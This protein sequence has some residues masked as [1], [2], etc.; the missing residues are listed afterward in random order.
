M[1]GLLKL[2]WV[3]TK[4]YLRE[5]GVYFGLALP[6][7]L[8]LVF[9][10]L[11]GNTP[12]SFTGGHGPMDVYTPAYIAMMI[13]SYSFFSLPI[14]IINYRE[15][16]ILFRLKA[17]PLRPQVILASHIGANFLMTTACS[18]IIVLLVRVFYDVHI[19]LSIFN[20]FVAYILGVISIFS[21]GFLLASLI[22]SV[23]I[24]SILN[25]ILF[26]ITLYLS[27]ILLPLTIFPPTL[28][29]FLQ[30]LPLTHVVILLQDLWLGG[31]WSD[32]WVN[33]L[34]LLGITIVCLFLSTK[35]FR[36]R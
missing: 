22:P 13:A 25:S 1:Q 21:F 5:P 3:E 33:V 17:T 32:H 14:T 2:T 20:V 6:V 9:G 19:T 29:N 31:S 26:G 24:A 34:A 28:R 15:R 16:G 30:I 35:L 12:N 36:W 10:T 11:Y 7:I 27:G 18:V 23:R 4:L 8:I